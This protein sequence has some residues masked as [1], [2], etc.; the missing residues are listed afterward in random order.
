MTF[1]STSAGY[2]DLEIVIT[3]EDSDK[4]LE[5]LEDMFS[6]FP[7]AIRKYIY[8]T[9]KKAYKYRCMPERYSSK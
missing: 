5:I 6:K 3:I 4:L 1:I 9:S 2:A 8:W 7:G